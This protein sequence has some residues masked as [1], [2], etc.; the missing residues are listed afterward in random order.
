MVGTE[1]LYFA[2][3][4]LGSA[5]LETVPLGYFLRP[6]TAFELDSKSPKE[7]ELEKARQISGGRSVC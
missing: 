5:D 4:R 7:K 2:G 1:A 3:S 6:V